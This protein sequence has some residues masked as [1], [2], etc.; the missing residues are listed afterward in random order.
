MARTG[1]YR[2]EVAFLSI[3]EKRFAG[4][5]YSPPLTGHSRRAGKN[6][7]MKP[8]ISVDSTQKRDRIALGELSNIGRLT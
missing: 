3:A 6:G 1:Y 7:G 2:S 5:F 8:I 4:R